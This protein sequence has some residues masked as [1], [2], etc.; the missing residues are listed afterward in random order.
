[1]CCVVGQKHPASPDISTT[2][3]GIGLA[4][5]GSAS[6]C[7][8]TDAASVLFS[9]V[10][11][12]VLPPARGEAQC[13]HLPLSVGTSG[14]KERT[15]RAEYAGQGEDS[16]GRLLR[17]GF[18]PGKCFPSPNAEECDFRWS[19]A[20]FNQLDAPKQLGKPQR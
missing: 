16:P 20:L 19:S 13:L 17:W 9:P 7:P 14:L 8:C 5:R 11:P 12:S 2:C 4:C 6:T 10:Q 1:M 15:L 3:C 18:L